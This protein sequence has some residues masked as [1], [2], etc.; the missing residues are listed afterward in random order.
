MVQVVWFKRDLRT[1]DHAPLAAAAVRGPVIP[2]YV[3]EPDYWRLP[4]TSARQWTFLRGTLEDLGARLVQLGAPL[5]ARMG[6]AEAILHDL[7]M[8][9]GIEGLWSHEETGNLWTFARDRRVAAFCRG[10]GIGWVQ[11]PQHGV[12]RGLRDRDRW[13][14]G[15]ARILAAPQVPEPIRLHGL[16]GLESE[17]LPA[18]DG[19]GL[20]PDGLR[21]MQPWG[22]ARALRLL[23]SFFAG[24]G[25]NYARGMSSPLTAASACSRLSPHLATGALSMREAVQRATA[26][27]IASGRLP[28]GEAAVPLR[29][30]DALIARLHWHCHFVQKLE[31]APDIEHMPQHPFFADAV[32]PENPALLHAWRT[33]R[34]GFPFLDACMRALIAKGWINF[35]MRAMLQSFASYQLGLDWRQSGAH[36]ARMF[37]DYEP[38]IHWPQVQMQSGLAGINTPR[39]YNP[40]KQSLDQDPDGAFVREWVPE[41]AGLPAALIHMPWKVD[42]ETLCAAGVILGRDYPAPVVDLS[43][44]VAAARARLALVRARPGFEA[45]AAQVYHKLGSRKRTLKNDDPPRRGAIAARKAEMAARQMTLDL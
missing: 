16:A 8:H 40:V 27:R 36:L 10:S 37:I 29:A 31:S 24:R 5:I 26:A 13:S 25:A 39:M 7:H 3:V 12:V 6:R 2:L 44:A 22:R 18:A 21:Q 1:S 34:T 4:D 33:G 32:Y 35:R 30:A 41:L 28:P 20:A 38:G 23:E 19:L 11:F 43:A 14:A 17:P 42:P 15:H 45:E 9:F